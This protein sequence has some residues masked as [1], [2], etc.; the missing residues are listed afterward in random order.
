M[1]EHDDVLK[2]LNRGMPL[3]DKLARVH[4]VLRAHTACIHRVAVALYDPKTDILKTFI[5][6]SNGSTPLARYEARLADCGSLQG[7]LDSGRPR[8]VTDLNLFEHST[9]EH[10]VRIR[11]QGYRASYT[12]PMYMDGA[13]FGFVFFNSYDLDPFT[14]EILHHLDVFGHLISLVIVSEIRQIHT[15]VGAIRAARTL[16]NERDFETGAHLDRMAHY[17][18][19]IARELA[20]K[21]GFSD[22]DIAHLF[23]FA[24]LHDIG[25]IGIPDAIL[26]KRATLTDAERAVMMTHAEKGRRIIDDMLREFALDHFHGVDML[27]NI[28]HCHHEALDGSGYPQGLKGEAIP[29]E[30]RIIAVADVFDALTSER[31]YKEAWSNDKA[32]A[33]LRQLAGA[34]LDGE[35]VEALVRNVTRVEEIQTRFR[36][37]VYG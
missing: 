18:Q 7:I 37:S 30:A 22:E 25:K 15:L 13:F 17:A 27:R 34:R 11:A 12:L 6:S 23:L 35:C 26:L 28:A 29:I 21:H 31:P 5:D 10:S 20:P 24:P 3:R 4:E 9:Q 32:F 36:E 14:P 19:L 2:E 16:T 8:V 33:A 1:T